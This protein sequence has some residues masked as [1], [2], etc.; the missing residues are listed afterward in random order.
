MYFYY[1]LL[2]DT[3]VSFYKVYLI[4]WVFVLYHLGGCF[5]A[6]DNIMEEEKEQAAQGCKRADSGQ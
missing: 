5:V 1:S 3:S 2:L 4:E 6:N